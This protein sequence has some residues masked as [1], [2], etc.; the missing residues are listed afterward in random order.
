MHKVSNGKRIEA[1]NRIMMPG[2]CLPGCDTIFTLKLEPARTSGTL[3]SYYNTT[4]RHNPED[5][6]RPQNWS[7]SVKNIT[8]FNRTE[9]NSEQD[10]QWQ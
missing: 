7:V 5:H 2:R 3:V 8:I 6:R 1:G 10:F 4:R 9:L